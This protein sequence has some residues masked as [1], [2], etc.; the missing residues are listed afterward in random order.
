MEP[1]VN[2]W[3]VVILLTLALIVLVSPGIV[4]RLAEKSVEANFEFATGD[5]DDITVTTERF[6][7]GWFTSE[8][9]HRIGLGDGMLGRLF[10][11][12]LVVDTH[13]DHGLVP[14]TS[15]S[16]DSGTLLPRLASTVSTVHLD[17]GSGE[18][19]DIP[20]KIYSTVG[21]T[22][23]TRSRYVLQ[24]GSEVSQDR[25]IEWQGANVTVTTNSASGEVSVDGVVRPW[26]TEYAGSENGRSVAM[27]DV[28]IS[29]RQEKT[30]YDFAVGNM[31]LQ[32][33]PVTVD[34]GNTPAGGFQGLSLNVDS[35]IEGDR[36][37]SAAKFSVTGIRN[38]LLGGL[39]IAVD[40]VLNGLDAQAI[41]RITRAFERLPGDPDPERALASIYPNIEADLRK[42]LSSGVELRVDRLDVS[43]PDGELTS[44]IRFNL[45]PTDAGN[46][47]SWPALLLALEAQADVRLPVALLEMIEAVK[48]DARMLVAMGIL[49]LEGNHYEM[50]A[51]YAKGLATI[52]GAPMPVPLQ[53]L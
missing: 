15:M 13:V 45:P 30:N 31:A 37:D 36:V 5:G 28:S 49:K 16:R 24:A 32:I 38:S 27:G 1:Y 11:G 46:D 12:E 22:G 7:R 2:R 29:A 4:G 41:E 14:V 9:R 3:I 48:P 44:K 8:G 17:T 53:A 19:I 50:R 47:F 34:N 52:N 39:D 40:M 33:G 25:R 18:F 20:G 43:L 35:S 42:I 23:E 51:E 26:N 6:E 10:E 21:L